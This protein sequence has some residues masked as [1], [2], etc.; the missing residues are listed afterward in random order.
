M[1]LHFPISELYTEY[2]PYELMRVALLTHIRFAL[3]PS[4]PP[5]SIYGLLYYQF[6]LDELYSQFFYREAYAMQ[7]ER[8]LSIS[9]TRGKGGKE[10]RRPWII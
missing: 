5:R 10:S 9:G 7:G 2:H 8:V 4:F 6:F 1:S 3:S